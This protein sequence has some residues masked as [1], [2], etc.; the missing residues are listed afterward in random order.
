MTTTK[1]RFNKIAG[2]C[3]GVKS[4]IRNKQWTHTNIKAVYNVLFPV[5]TLYLQITFTERL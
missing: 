2:N 4:D 3:L 1:I 5:I